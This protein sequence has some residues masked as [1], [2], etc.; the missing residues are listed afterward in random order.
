MLVTQATLPGVLNIAE[1]VH[2]L[3]DQMAG[4]HRIPKEAVHLV[5]NKVRNSTLTPQEV[6]KLGGT[7]RTDFP[8]LTAYLPDDPQIEE[9]LK[10]RRPAWNS[11]EPLRRVSRTLGDLLFAAP[12]T[13][14]RQQDAQTGKPARVWTLG[15][16]RIK[17]S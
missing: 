8:S 3:N 11:S 15:P 6:V 13:M 7:V 2:L 16:L 9:A 17:A 1:A 10:L 4:R 12:A 5:V 14:A